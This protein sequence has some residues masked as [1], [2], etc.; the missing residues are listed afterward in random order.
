VNAGGAEDARKEA[1]ESAA[2]PKLVADLRDMKFQPIEAS[3]RAL[4]R[5]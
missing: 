3:K 4:N 1:S 5:P 2:E